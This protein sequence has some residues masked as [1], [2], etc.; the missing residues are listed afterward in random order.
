[1]KN[2]ILVLLLTSSIVA[3]G[4]NEKR[5]MKADREFSTEQQA[6]LKTKKMTLVLDLNDNQQRQMLAL[7]KKWMQEKESAKAAYQNF[8]RQEL[9][10]D[11]KFEIMNKNLDLKIE[12]Q[13]ELKG[14]LDKDQ[15]A[16]WKESTMKKQYR[17]KAKEKHGHKKEHKDQKN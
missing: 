8:T 7:N 1:M 15:Y 10:A 16:L 17:S 13:K 2:L 14:V 6:I 9:T 11:Q 4:Q 12:Q 3:I 5:K